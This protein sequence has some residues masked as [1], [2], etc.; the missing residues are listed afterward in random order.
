MYDK[1]LKVVFKLLNTLN[2]LE[3]PTIVQSM[4]RLF[5]G[6]TERT[7]RRMNEEEFRRYIGDGEFSRYTVNVK[8]RWYIYE[9]DGD[10]YYINPKWFT[11]VIDKHEDIMGMFE[12]LL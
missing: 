1:Y 4:Y 7:V 6:T 8:P 10:F 2:K 5:D 11:E 9:A 3:E 12:E